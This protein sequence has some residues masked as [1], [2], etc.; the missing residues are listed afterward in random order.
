MAAEQHAPFPSEYDALS[1]AIAMYDAEDARIE[2]TN[3]RFESLF[4][5]AAEELRTLSPGRYTANTYRFSAADFAERLRDA[6]G[7][8]PQQFPWRIKRADGELT[9]V[10][11]SLS[12][13]DGGRDAHVLAEVRD[14]TEHYAASRRETLFWRVLRHNL[15]NEANKLV[16]YA[17]AVLRE[18]DRDGLREAGRK[19][20]ATALDLGTIATSVKEIQQ[21]A[22]QSET[23]RS[24]RPAADAVRDVI[25]V[26]EPSYPDATFCLE[27]R[28]PMWVRVDAA[29]DHALRHAL[30]NAV[31]HADE[32]DPTVEVTVGPSP[33]TGR[34]EIRV[35]DTN[36]YIPQVEVDALD[37][38]SE[39]TT[40]RHGTGV[41]LFVMQWCVESLG[42]ELTFERRE[43]RGN[44]VRFYL[45]PQR[46]PGDPPSSD[47]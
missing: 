41:G 19:A 11:V 15:R 25:A 44:R 31:C 26:L 2:R 12:A 1:L 9:W 22:A 35:S 20:R 3:G 38:V 32:S 16:G 13:W 46:R 42:G 37:T 24:P 14:I 36:P 29:F 21:A 10:R 7:G 27:E 47:P 4:G 6:A 17:E 40:T 43:P 30:E 33:N 39:L 5:Y 18:T 23:H 34:V 8:D 28:R 45:P